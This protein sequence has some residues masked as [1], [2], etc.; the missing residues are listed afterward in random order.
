MTRTAFLATLALLPALTSRG[1]AQGA[2]FGPVTAAVER[3]I[4]RG[5][6]PG[7]VV[8]IG[9]RDTILF[10]RG[11]GRLTWSRTAAR[12][13]AWTTLWDVA[14][15][16][17]VVATTGVA[18]ALVDRGLLELDAPVQRYLPRFTGPGKD[19]VTVRMLLNHTSGMR[20]YLP[21]F[22]LASTR[23]GAIDLVLA[24]PLIRE[25]G[26]EA[27]YSD[28]NAILLGLLLE[29]VTGRPLS[30]A[31]TELVFNPL[32][33]GFTTFMPL[34]PEQAVVAP[35][36]MTG[37]RPEPGVVDDPNARRLG[38]VA[39][40][41]GL[42]ST[43]LDLARYAQAWLRRGAGRGGPWISE[44]TVA[45][46]LTRT[47][48]SG[49]RFLG[50]DSPERDQPE[51]SVFGT[52]PSPSSFGHTGWTGTMLWVDPERDLFFVMLT[53]R[54]LDPRNRRSLTA[55]REL[56]SELSDLVTRAALASCAREQAALC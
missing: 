34:I 21:L 2:S 10:A 25:P 46:F 38:G 18:A 19:R 6:F 50:W 52:L 49:S 33:M 27:L 56:R 48:A 28:L 53:N 7:A 36:R 35:S 22:R 47:P 9:R 13:S 44:Q 23:Q 41:A 40:H 8:V 43:G 30:H 31:A 16:T 24:E 39:G 55:I 20:A 45:T 15:L 54:S 14:S 51:P 3:G 5:V 42:F 32:R 11:F 26:S 4:R 1:S 29:E 12:P 17:K 37:R